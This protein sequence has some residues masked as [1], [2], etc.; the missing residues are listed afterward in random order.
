MHNK[1]AVATIAVVIV[2]ALVA[3]GGLVY[4]FRQRPAPPAQTVQQDQ[5]VSSSSP[6]TNLPVSETPHILSLS[7]SS[8]RVGEGVYIVGSG[9][10]KTTTVYLNGYAVPTQNNNCYA[11]LRTDGKGIVV[12]V[13]YVLNN[14]CRRDT[15]T[16]LADYVGQL[17]S[18]GVYKVQV[19]NA[20]GESNLVPFTVVASDKT[21]TPSISSLSPSSGPAG[22]AVTIKGS[23]FD[24]SDYHLFFGGRSFPT[25]ACYLSSME[26]RFVIPG[27]FPRS[28]CVPMGRGTTCPDDSAP[29]VPGT[30]YVQVGRGNDSSNPVT[31][32]VTK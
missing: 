27:T 8:G 17:V 26:L 32:T 7:A 2:V 20:G 24:R 23:N 29:V 1:Q 18:P 16:S 25:N 9:L 30:Y 5:I 14:Y 6:T 10:D 15:S 31:F 21:P 19:R 22:T 12:T 13:P 11:D 4:M 3:I 28:D